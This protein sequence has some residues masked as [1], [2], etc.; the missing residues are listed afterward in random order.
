M[1]RLSNSKE[2]QKINADATKLKLEQ[3]SNRGG[4]EKELLVSKIEAKK[5]EMDEFTSYIASLEEA[6]ASQ[7]AEIEKLENSQA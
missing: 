1:N 7:L 4:E 3:Y 2:E 5:K 6:E